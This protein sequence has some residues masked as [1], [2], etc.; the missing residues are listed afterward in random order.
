MRDGFY[1]RRV[2]SRSEVDHML[3]EIF[4]PGKF[5]QTVFGKI[6]LQL[7]RRYSHRVSAQRGGPRSC[8]HAA[9]ERLRGIDYGA[10]AARIDP[11]LF[12]Q[13]LDQDCVEA[14]AHL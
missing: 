3:P 12:T 11:R 9:V 7:E 13:A 5:L 1:N 6:C 4:P 14:L 10:H 2:Q 8:R